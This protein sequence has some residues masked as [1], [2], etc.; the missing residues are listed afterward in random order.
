MCATMM[1]KGT[2]R[3]PKANNRAGNI[4]LEMVLQLNIS[5]NIMFGN[6]VE[7]MGLATLCLNLV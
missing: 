4:V 1:P 2:S 7:Q 3:V 5:S 6:D